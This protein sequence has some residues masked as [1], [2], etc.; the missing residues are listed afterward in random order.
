LG[1]KSSISASN[2]GWHARISA[3][4]GFL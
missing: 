4:V 3:M 1:F 2:Q